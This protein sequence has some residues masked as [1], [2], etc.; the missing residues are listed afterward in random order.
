[1]RQAVGGGF[2]LGRRLG[3]PRRLAVGRRSRISAGLLTYG[4]RSAANDVDVASD[5]G[6]VPDLLP[7]LVEDG[8]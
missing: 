1:M 8:G 6:L 2:G 5:I 3:L 7:A 4:A